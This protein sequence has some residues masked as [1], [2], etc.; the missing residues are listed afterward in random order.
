MPELLPDELLYSFVGRMSAMNALGNTR[1]RMHLLFGAKNL[2]PVVDMPTRVEHLQLALGSLSPWKSG[3]EAIDDATVYP[4]HRPFVPLQRNLAIESILLG[5]S[6]K[7]LKTLLGR[8]A[9]RF[10]A[11]PK[12][13]FCTA[14]LAADTHEYGAPY[15]HRAHQLPGVMACQIHGQGLLEYS[16]TFHLT[17]RQRISLAPAVVAEGVTPSTPHLHQ[18]AFALLSQ[19]L[20]RARLPVLGKA[21]QSAYRGTIKDFGLMRR[22][23]IDYR[24]LAIAV[25]AHYCDFDGFSHRDRILSTKRKPLSWLRSL[26]E[27]PDRSSHPICHLLLIG[28][29]F[30]TVEKF[31]ACVTSESTSINGK[32]SV[33]IA[34]RTSRL[35][36]V[37]DHALLEDVSLSCREVAGLTK[38]SVTTIVQH[39]RILGVKISERPKNSRPG[40]TMQILELLYAGVAPTQIAKN[41]STS[42]ST[43]YR[44]RAQSHEFVQ[45][46]EARSFEE[47]R[48]RRRQRWTTLISESGTIGPKALRG[49]CS[50]DF[51][52][53]YRNDR[54]WLQDI[55]VRLRIRR[56]PHA[57]VDWVARD[58]S[59]CAMV[60]AYVETV[61]SAGVRPRISRTLMARHVG[62]ATVRANLARLPKFVALL[63][64]LEENKLSYQCSRI[65]YATDKL[66]QD[67]QPIVRWKIQRSAG[68]RDW[69]P[70]HTIYMQSIIDSREAGFSGFRN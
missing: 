6:G 48:V 33:H 23:Y 34:A 47:E 37:P 36:P 1:E 46:I 63:S 62:E 21:C 4:Y 58:N 35:S 67:G 22:Q 16:K 13:R 2:I 7:S 17:D 26:I 15:W 14:C 38:R 11:A 54:E 60:R 56:E 9:N 27:R 45:M 43:V 66:I 51:A 39:R 52:W 68:V 12:L 57:R 8:V 59:Y 24:A 40:M 55:C 50:K 49:K 18:I 65:K 70:C 19:E 20:L 29:L 25:R 69:K 61:Q 42:L 31:R 10:G 64:E 32:P 53:L 41:C 5:S 44:L 28:F 30:Q 3:M